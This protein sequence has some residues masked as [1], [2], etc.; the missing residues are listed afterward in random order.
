MEAE[1]IS[2][3]GIRITFVGVGCR[4][5]NPNNSVANV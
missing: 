3:S 2:S 1:E 4:Y 5:E